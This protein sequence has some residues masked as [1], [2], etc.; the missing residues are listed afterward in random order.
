MNPQST[1]AS[2]HPVPPA[3]PT[4]EPSTPKTRRNGKIA[5]LPFKLRELIN[6]MLRDGLPYSAIIQKLA[7]HGHALNHDNL[8]RWFAGGHRDWLQEQAY[9]DE[10]RLKLN[11]ASDILRQDNSNVFNE[12]TLRIAVTRMYNLLMDFDPAVLKQSL[13]TAPG[14]Y[15]RLLNSLTNL[16][17]AALK[18]ERN[19]AEYTRQAART[20]QAISGQTSIRS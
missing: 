19:R 18:L 4:P 16:T 9:L 17:D 5:R 1:S 20:Q 12:A 11:F 14:I 10:I 2:L 13:S 8:S 3:A 7:E 6:L 15:A